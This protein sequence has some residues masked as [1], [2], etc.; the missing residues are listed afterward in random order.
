MAFKPGQS[1]NPNGRPKGET[2]GDIYRKD[3]KFPTMVDKKF[4]KLL[5]S[6]DESIVLSTLKFMVEMRDGK[7]PQPLSNP[8]GS[9]LT[10]YVI[11]L[12]SQTQGKS[13][14]ITE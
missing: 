5:E 9:N 1:G 2:L 12:P 6:D 4:R 8:D 7:A 10:T 14:G 13:G 11:A 3:K